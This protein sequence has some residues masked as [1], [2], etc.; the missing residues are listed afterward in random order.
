MGLIDLERIAA[1]PDS[2][3]RIALQRAQ[4]AADAA[5]LVLADRTAERDYY[6]RELDKRTKGYKTVRIPD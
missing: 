1:M 5:R 3:L 2:E 4:L 6:Q